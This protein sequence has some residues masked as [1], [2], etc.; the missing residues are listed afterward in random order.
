M[1]YTVSIGFHTTNAVR[2]YFVIL[3]VSFHYQVCNWMTANNSLYPITFKVT[4]LSFK[5]VS[6]GGSNL[7]CTHT[8]ESFITLIS[9]SFTTFSGEVK[10]VV[11]LLVTE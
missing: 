8:V 4:E 5:I 3:L 6:M 9:K 1:K 7:H 11:F 10:K 2:S